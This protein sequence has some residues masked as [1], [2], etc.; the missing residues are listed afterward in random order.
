MNWD[1]IKGKWQ[2]IKG[3]VKPQRRKLTHREMFAFDSERD[4]L[5]GRAQ[6][7]YSMVKEVAEK[8]IKDF[9]KS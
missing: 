9:E 6:Q 5:T 3:L 1:Q 8:Q 7:W 2:L 4:V